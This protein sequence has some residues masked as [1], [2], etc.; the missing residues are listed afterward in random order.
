[1]TTRLHAA[2]SLLLLAGCAPPQDCPRC[3]RPVGHGV[4]EHPE[5]VEISGLA[6]SARLDGVV[7]THNDSSDSSRLFA[8]DRTGRSLGTIRVADAQNDDWEDVARGPCGEDT[9]LFVG[10]IGDNALDRDSYAIYVLAEPTALD[11]GEQAATAQR[12][13]FGYEDGRHD[14]EVLLVHP[15]TGAVTIVTKPESGPASIYALPL[16]L[17][18]ARVHAATKVGEVD[19]PEGSARFTGG[20]IHPRARGILLRTETRLF[21]YP[22]EADESAA[23]ALTAGG[24]PLALADESQGEAVTWLGEGDE[25]MTLGEGQSAPVNISACEDA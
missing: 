3:D 10:D 22:M 5:L 11:G 17:D 7:Y 24:C 16:P 19:P 13:V 8:L 1:M 6:A 12:I 21:H 20:A 25:I 9:C 18:P 23:E 15:W 2:I 14:A 4:V